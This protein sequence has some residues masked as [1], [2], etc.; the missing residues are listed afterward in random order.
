MPWQNTPNKPF[1]LIHTS[2]S[3]ITHPTIKNIKSGVDRSVLDVASAGLRRNLARSQ[4]M[5][6]RGSLVQVFRVMQMQP[7]VKGVR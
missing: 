5:G 4:P 2:R 7:M 3:H 1:L 6:V